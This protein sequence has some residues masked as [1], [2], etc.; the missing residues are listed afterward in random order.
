MLRSAAALSSNPANASCPSTCSIHLAWPKDMRVSFKAHGHFGSVAHG[1]Y[2]QQAA[3]AC[4]R[5]PAGQ[6]PAEFMRQPA[7]S[8]IHA[9]ARSF[10]IHDCLPEVRCPLV[11]HSLPYTSWPGT[12]L[13]FLYHPAAGCQKWV[14]IDISHASSRERVQ[15][16]GGTEHVCIPLQHSLRLSPADSLT[17]PHS[18]TGIYNV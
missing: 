11:Y 14:Q 9:C 2:R 10:S 1:L 5:G 3:D 6:Q 15:K 13:L 4:G 16:P 12:V 7:A 17:T 8:R 18:A